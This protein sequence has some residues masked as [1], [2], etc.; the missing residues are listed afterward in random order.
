MS[1]RDVGHDGGQFAQVSTGMAHAVEREI[2]QHLLA[3]AHDGTEAAIDLRS[4]P[5][6]D[7]DRAELEESLGRGEVSATLDAMGRSDIW[8]TAHAG[9][10]WVRHFG[11]EG[12]VM[13]E[14]IEIARVPDILRADPADVEAAAIRLGRARDF[15][16]AHADSVAGG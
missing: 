1:P 14:R 2:G 15:I 6:S 10:W 9:V 11:T 3:L 13:A 16:D 12:Q 4:I 8:E 5:M 7:A